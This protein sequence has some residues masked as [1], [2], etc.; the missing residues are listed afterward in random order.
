MHARIEFSHWLSMYYEYVEG[1]YEKM[2]TSLSRVAIYS[3][4]Y[5]I[6]IDKDKLFDDLAYHMYCTSNNASKYYALR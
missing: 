5:N 1:T 4:I 2:M 6:H 3:P